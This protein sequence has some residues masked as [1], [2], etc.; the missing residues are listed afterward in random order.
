MGSDRRTAKAERQ[1]RW[2]T[3]NPRSEQTGQNGTARQFGCIG[4]S[5]AAARERRV[6]LTAIST[7]PVVH[8]EQSQIA[9]KE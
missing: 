8:C 5:S 7:A 9:I 1:L 2:L 3:S 6:E 4:R